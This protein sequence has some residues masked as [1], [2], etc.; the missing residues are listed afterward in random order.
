MASERRRAV[1]LGAGMA[2]LLA[3]RVLSDHYYEVVVVERDA[4]PEGP[5]NRR[6]VPQGLHGHTLLPG[7]CQALERLLPGFL[8]ALATSGVPVVDQ[9]NQL[10]FA[11]GGRPLRLGQEL[12]GDLSTYVPSRPHLEWQV[13]RRVS[14]LAN[15]RILDHH[16]ATGPVTDTNATGASRVV[17]VQV[18]GRGPAQAL[19]ADLVVDARGRGA[20]T[21]AWLEQVGLARPSEQRVGVDTRYATHPVRIPGSAL[22]ERLV[23]VGANAGCHRGLGLFAHEDDTW[24][25]TIFGVRG[26]RPPPEHGAMVKYVSDLVP[27]HIVRALSSAQSLGPV[28]SHHF[29]ASRW[30]R[31][32]TTRVPEG[33]IVIG[34][35]VCSLNP[36][37]GQGM[38]VATLQAEALASALVRGE[39]SRTFHAAAAKAIAPAWQLAQSGDRVHQAGPLPLA[40]R[41]DQIAT[42]TFLRAATRDSILA[43]RFL[44]VLGM[45]ERPQLLEAPSSLLRLARGSI[46]A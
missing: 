21:P 29:P 40:E 38:T 42:R 18:V 5:V 6:G 31:Y 17:G 9:P 20:A 36:V 41:L 28:R 14:E 30:H 4:L 46:L 7:G 11:P 39:L 33:L 27:G 2:G 3:A 37:Y 35:A 1:V 12:S 24:E 13:R 22:R 8:H 26:Q 43:E 44:R 15:V 25:F 32:D 10:Y 16:E 45:L 34:D 23:L 19:D